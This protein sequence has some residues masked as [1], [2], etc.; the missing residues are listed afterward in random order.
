MPNLAFL[1]KWDPSIHGSSSDEGPYIN[2]LKTKYLVMELVWGDGEDSFDADMTLQENIEWLNKYHDDPCIE[3]ETLKLCIIRNMYRYKD[4]DFGNIN[5]GLE[6]I[7][8][9][10]KNYYKRRM[11]FL[12]SIKN[13]NYRQSNGKY[14]RSNLI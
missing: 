10:W 1:M 7:Q 2:Y 13:L 3:P 6:K 14:P 8:R 9:H 11:A 12:K 4:R 5:Y